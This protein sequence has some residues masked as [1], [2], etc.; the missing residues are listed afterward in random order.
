VRGAVKKAGLQNPVLTN[1]KYIQRHDRVGKQARLVPILG[2]FA[3]PLA[4]KLYCVD[5][6]GIGGKNMP[7]S[8]KNGT[9]S[10]EILE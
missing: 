10:G 4:N 1:R 9:G 3:K 5:V 2:I 7:L 8:R 6:P